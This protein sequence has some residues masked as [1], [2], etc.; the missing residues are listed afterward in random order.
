M[1]DYFGSLGSEIKAFDTISVTSNG[2]K[3]VRI[4]R[5]WRA[6]ASTWTHVVVLTMNGDNKLNNCDRRGV[7]FFR[8]LG[9]GKSEAAATRIKTEWTAIRFS[10]A[11]FG[12]EIHVW[13][14]D[15]LYCVSSAEISESDKRSHKAGILRLHDMLHG[16]RSLVI[17]AQWLLTQDHVTLPLNHRLHPKQVTATLRPFHASPEIPVLP[18]REET[19]RPLLLPANAVPIHKRSSKYVLINVIPDYM[20][21]SSRVDRDRLEKLEACVRSVLSELD[22]SATSAT[23]D[24]AASKDDNR[25]WMAKNILNPGIELIITAEMEEVKEEADIRP[26]PWYQP[27]IRILSTAVSSEASSDERKKIYTVL[28]KAVPDMD[29]LEFSSLGCTYL[30]KLNM[31]V[32]SKTWRSTM[33]NSIMAGGLAAR[34]ENMLDAWEDMNEGLPRYDEEKESKAKEESKA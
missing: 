5:K 18:Q 26:C 11:A 4:P 30:D 2:V 20:Y 27:L 16:L 29:S 31:S 17:R 13:S 12:G 7:P 33:V 1:T 15:K 3:P 6:F 28:T 21:L 8:I 25:P 14:A 19:T 10:E 22:K 24:R 23:G 32:V 34:S 9:L